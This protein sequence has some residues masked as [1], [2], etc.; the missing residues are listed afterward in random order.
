MIQPFI[1]LCNEIGENIIDTVEYLWHIP[2]LLLGLYFVTY[3][4]V[5]WFLVELIKLIIR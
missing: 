2:L 5:M 4:C 3:L 1:C